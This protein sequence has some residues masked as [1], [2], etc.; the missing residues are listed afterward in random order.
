[1]EARP[2]SADMTEHDDNGRGRFNEY[3]VLNAEPAIMSAAHITRRGFEGMHAL[4]L[5]FHAS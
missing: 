1:M 5:G 3:L 2:P 4:A